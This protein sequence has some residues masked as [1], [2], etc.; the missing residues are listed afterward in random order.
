MINR[1][2]Y[3]LIF[4]IIILNIYFLFKSKTEYNRGIR[5]NRGKIGN[6]GL[7]GFKGKKGLKGFR[8]NIGDKGDFNFNS[9]KGKRGKMGERGDRG[10]RGYRGNRGDIGDKGYKGQPGEIGN[11]GLNGIQ[12]DIGEKGDTGLDN[13]YKFEIKINN[14]LFYDSTN[15]LETENSTKFKDSFYPLR[16]KIRCLNKSTLFGG[17]YNDNRACAL[18][19]HIMGI[20]LKTNGG[21]N[22]NQIWSN[23]IVGYNLSGESIIEDNSKG[24]YT[25]IKIKN[26]I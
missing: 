9:F 5:G 10:D 1:L 24:Y 11:T 25:N 13:I 6:K 7:K 4:Y 18:D 26:D 23:F 19:D 8:G 17:E 16:G 12:G 3:I 2:I 15:N 14:N 20:S 22:N 21:I